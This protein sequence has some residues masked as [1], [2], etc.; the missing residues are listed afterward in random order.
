MPL[1]KKGA[2]ILAEL[3]KQY[4]PKKGARVLYAGENKGTFKGIHARPKR[5]R[6]G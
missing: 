6:R 3:K 2:K 1:T 4:G 5:G